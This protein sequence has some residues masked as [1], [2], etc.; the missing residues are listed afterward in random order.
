MPGLDELRR[1]VEAAEEHFGLMST[2]SRKY[3]ERLTSLVS[4]MELAHAEQSREIAQLNGRLGQYE[5]ENGQLKSMLMG[6]LQAIEHGSDRVIDH[7]V[8]DLEGRVGRLV[9]AQAVAEQDAIAIDLSEEFDADGAVGYADNDGAVDFAEDGAVDFADE[10][11]ASAA[12]GALPR[13]E[14]ETVALDDVPEERETLT[15]SAS[16]LLDRVEAAANALLAAGMDADP[17][18]ED[19]ELSSEISA[20]LASAMA[21]EQADDEDEPMLM[22]AGDADEDQPEQHAA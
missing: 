22:D 11:F 3:S 12:V 1:R 20:L 6:L 14:P 16:D 13:P 18:E 17:G 10:G 8:R 9:G 7:A 19:A 2:Q 15:D 21:G 5:Q 4:Q